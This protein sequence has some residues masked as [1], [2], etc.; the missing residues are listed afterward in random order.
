MQEKDPVKKDTP[1]TASKETQEPIKQGREAIEAARQ[2]DP[3]PADRKEKEK[4][5]A[6]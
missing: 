5:D 1:T 4:K 2:T 3:D 6:E